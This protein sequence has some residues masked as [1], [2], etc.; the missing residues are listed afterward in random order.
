IAGVFFFGAAASIGSVLDR[1]SDSHKAL[2]VDLSAVPFLDATGANTLES[3]ARKA[4]AR[5]TLVFIH[6]GSTEIRRYLERHEIH[7]PLVTFANS[8]EAA[9]T[10]A[11]R[12][13]GEAVN[14]H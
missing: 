9:R 8:I 3:L 13:I 10:E 2:I 1:I 14:G 7:E 6:A 4:V 5:G 12:R 11:R